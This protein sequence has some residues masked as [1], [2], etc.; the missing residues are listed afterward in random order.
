MLSWI[1]STGKISMGKESKESLTPMIRQYHALKERYP[2]KILLFRLGDFYETF[3]EDAR[4]TSQLLGIVLT[5]RPVGKNKRIPMAGIPYHALE[6]YLTR[7]LKK[8]YKVAICEQVED[9]KKARGLVKREVVRVITPGTILEE[10]ILRERENNYLLSLNPS[11]ERWGISWVDISTGEMW[12]WEERKERVSSQI[13]KLSPREILLPEDFSFPSSQGDWVITHYP[14]WSYF[15]ERGEEILC[16]HF[17][18]KN[19]EGLG[20][21]GLDAG[22]GACGALLSYLEDLEG[23][24]PRNLVNIRLFRDEEFVTLDPDTVRNLELVRN[25]RGEEEGTLL[26]VLDDTVTPMGGR[27]LKKW[28]LHPLRKIPLIEERLDAIEEL[29]EKSAEPLRERLSRMG[30]LERILARIERGLARPRDMVALRFSLELI[31]EIKERLTPFTSSLLREIRESLDPLDSLLELL[32][33]SIVEDPPSTLK[34]G[35]IIREGFSS[36]LDELREMAR[37]GKEWVAKLQEEEIRKTGIKSLKVGYNKVFGYY[38]EVTKANLHLVPS[39]YI[40]KQTLVNAERFI[41]PELKDKETL[42]LHAEER[43]KELEYEIFQKIR[44]EVTRYIIPLQKNAYYIAQLDALISLARVSLKFG[45]TR[46][47]IVEE[48][49]IEIEEGRHPVLERYLEEPFVPNDTEILPSQPILI[50]TGPNMAGKSTYIRQVALITL[51]AHM[52]S[53]V[54][55]RK[56]RIGLVDRIFTRVGAGDELL[57]QRSTFM[58]EMNEVASILRN[59]TEKSLIILDEVGRGT[60]TYDGI[61]IAWA[62]GEYIHDHLRART[63]FATHYHEITELALYLPGVRNYHIQVR[64]WGGKVIF[65]RKIKEGATDK[66]YGIHVAQL[67]GVPEEVIRRAREVLRD[68]ER[69]HVGRKGRRVHEEKQLPLFAYRPHPV[70]EKLKEINLERLSPLE[71][72][73]LLRNLLE[74]V[75]DTD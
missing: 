22:I 42:I 30:D 48:K 7:F 5:S 2:D 65:L 27:M 32:R 33:K 1:K 61:S 54:P 63:L 49:V 15:R 39:H 37:G 68:M 21:G 3:Y 40:R 6:T 71:A 67:A 64:E 57:R 17:G 55:A 34:E 59:A 47:E 41:T 66:S 18:V 73:D 12:V 75:E 69:R 29:R 43:I 70:V 60:S 35:G 8:G 52:G 24:I 10:N 13:E 44:E 51:L 62:V 45:Y 4:I 11:G 25:L 74:E 72:F 26:E 14:S 28:L 46:P 38:I 19:I 31:P 56:A 20:L 50:L 23:E 16:R 36:E 53:F 58:V 9:P